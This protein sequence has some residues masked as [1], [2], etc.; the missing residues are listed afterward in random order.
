MRVEVLRHLDTED[1]FCI[2]WLVRRSQGE[3]VVSACRQTVKKVI[4]GSD[5]R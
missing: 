4:D 5:G 1:A 3:L 2:I